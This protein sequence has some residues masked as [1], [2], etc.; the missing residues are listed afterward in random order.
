[1]LV[2]LGCCRMCT[3]QRVL[4]LI[5]STQ[6]SATEEVSWDDISVTW[7]IHLL[8]KSGG[9]GKMD[10][11]EVN[12]GIDNGNILFLPILLNKRP[13]T[14]SQAEAYEGIVKT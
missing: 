14:T 12:P 10:A 6:A 5:L 11:F 4:H 7:S 13:A 9:T 1:M 2:G 3:A 8:N